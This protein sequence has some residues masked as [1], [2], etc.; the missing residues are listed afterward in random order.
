MCYEVFHELKKA[1]QTDETTGL[2]FRAE[3]LDYFVRRR[4]SYAR[5]IAADT[6]DFL[7]HSPKAGEK[8]AKRASEVLESYASFIEKTKTN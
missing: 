8:A 1:R 6:I 3:L 2:E 4:S 5:E 7:K